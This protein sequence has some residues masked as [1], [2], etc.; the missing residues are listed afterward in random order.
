[1][2]E[3]NYEKS[4]TRIIQKLLDH[5]DVFI[6]IG[7]NIGYYC[8]MALSKNIHTLAVEPIPLNLQVLYRNLEANGWQNSVEVYPM[9]IGNTNGIV[10]IYGQSTGA[11]LIKGWA[12]N[13]EKS[14]TRV[15]VIRFDTLFANRFM[16]NRC[17]L[18]V[19]IEGAERFMLE[20]AQDFLKRKNCCWVMEISTTEN[21]PPE[22]PI[23]PNLSWTFNQFWNKGFECR[24][25]A[26]EL[27]IITPEIVARMQATGETAYPTYNYLFIHK[28]S[29]LIEEILEI[30]S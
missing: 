2:V 26:D 12:E 16:D 21:Q 24:A 17:L 3:G 8:C 27:P 19:D 15:P 28:D 29:S 22:I 5:H 11:S 13:S 9:A 30:L 14:Y 4:T 1:M 7:A 6:N 18:L 10:L 20:G 23:N 25:V